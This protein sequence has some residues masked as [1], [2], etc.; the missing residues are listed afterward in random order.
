MNFFT[1]KNKQKWLLIDF[2]HQFE[3]NIEIT[4]NSDKKLELRLHM[5]IDINEDYSFNEKEEGKEK[6]EI[7][8]FASLDETLYFLKKITSKLLTYCFVLYDNNGREIETDI[9]RKNI[10]EY[11]KTFN[12]EK[13]SNK[14]ELKQKIEEIYNFYD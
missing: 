8:K 7:I 14:K 13:P 9:A 10:K 1:N 12:L 6:K 5:W 3:K 11:I 4:F 2:D